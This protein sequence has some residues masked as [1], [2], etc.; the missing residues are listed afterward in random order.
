MVALC[1]GLA[2]A[3]AVTRGRGWQR[4]VSAWWRLLPVVFVAWWLRPWGIWVLVL[5][6]GALAIREL[7]PH[8]GAQVPQLRRSLWLCW[9]LQAAVGVFHPAWV[10]GTAAA[11]AVGLWWLHHQRS[12]PRELLLALFALQAAGLWCLPLL[13]GWPPAGEAGEAGQ[14]AAAWFLYVCIVT[15]LNDVAQFVSGKLWGRHA[16]ARRVSPNKTWQGALGGLV[17]SMLVSVAVGRTLGLASVPELVVLGGLLCATGLVGDLLFSA[18]KR[19]L[20]IKDYSTLIPGHGGIL[21]RVDSLVLTA[22]TLWLALHL[23]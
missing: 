21:D 20:G 18:G 2:F 9:A 4:Q 1:L 16:I 19:A 22:P 3:T 13:A 14:P 15:A 11:G 5:L 17:V 8:A 7:A 10:A 23:V 6:I 12:Q